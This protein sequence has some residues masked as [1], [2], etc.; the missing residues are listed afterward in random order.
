MARYSAIYGT[1]RYGESNYGVMVNTLNS[2]S[3]ILGPT[4][5]TTSPSICTA[6]ALDPPIISSASDLSYNDQSQS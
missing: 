6:E 1:G 4:G 3:F 5:D 2:D